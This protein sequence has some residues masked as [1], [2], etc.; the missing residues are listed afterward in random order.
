MPSLSRSRLA[1]LAL[2]TAACMLPVTGVVPILEPLLLDRLGLQDLAASSFMALNMAGALVAA[3]F[4]GRLSDARGWTRRLIAAAATLEAVVLV[5]MTRAATFPELAALR[6]LDGVAHITVL[7][8]LLATVSRRGAGDG[9]RPRMAL[10]GGAIVFG[11]ALGAPLGGLLGRTSPDPPLLAG[12]AVMVV[13]ALV[14]PFV[15]PA[16]PA[17]PRVVPSGHSLLRPPPRLRL[18]YLFAFVDR[19][20]VGFFVYA[21]PMYTSRELGLDPAR[22]GLL[23]GTFMLPFALL[24]YPAGRVAARGRPWRVVLLGSA[25]YAVA[26]AAIPWL[27]EV[28]LWPAMLC[29]GVLSAV[30]FG[31]NLVLV[32]DGS[33]PSTRAAA[34]AGFNAAGALGFLIG[35]LVAGAL[36]QALDATP[37]AYHLTFALGAATQLGAIAWAVHSLRRARR[38][39][40]A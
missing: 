34:M 28:G 17:D 22:T 3:P 1:V 5:L 33:T 40:T 4:V 12:A 11:V 8:L 36:L 6:V 7:T 27:G 25:G 37:T 13:V 29:G 10:L 26:Y 31:P 35:P 14:A 16:S 15:V 21:F 9:H 32:L 18:P 23:I 2:L 19:L 20:T 30:M 39:D 24:C 38:N